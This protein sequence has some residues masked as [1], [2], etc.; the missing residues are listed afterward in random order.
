[1]Q[2]F[3]LIA[4]VVTYVGSVLFFTR[5]ANTF[6]IL[7]IPLVLYLSGACTILFYTPPRYL[8]ATLLV[9]GAQIAMWSYAIPEVR[10]D[11]PPFVNKGV[12]LMSSSYMLFLVCIA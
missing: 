11:P 1:M 12:A 6:L 5:P 10:E 3:I 2:V 9:L 4:F 8:P 7:F